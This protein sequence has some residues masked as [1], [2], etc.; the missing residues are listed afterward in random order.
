MGSRFL[1]ANLESPLTDKQEI[2]RRYG[3]IETLLTEFIKKEE[4]REAL[5]QVYDLERLSSRVSYGNLNARDLLQLRN[6]L[7]SLPVIHDILEEIGYDKNVEVLPE[8]H[9]LLEKSI[10]EDAPLN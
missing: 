8:L 9:E 4:L 10:S 1:K 6:S 5:D 3:I 7:S 2:L